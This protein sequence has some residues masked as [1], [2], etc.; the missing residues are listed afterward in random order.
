MY[1]LRER[2]QHVTQE[3]FEFAVAKVRSSFF[4]S[5]VKHPIGSQF[6]HI[7]PEKEPRREHKCQQTL[8]LDIMTCI[9]GYLYYRLLCSFRPFAIEEEQVRMPQKN[10][11]LSCSQLKRALPRSIDSGSLG[12]R[13]FTSDQVRTA[14]G[15]G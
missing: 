13:R 7:G 12:K 11:Y 1:A 3:D 9:P 4:H 5:S 15:F 10:L 6:V 8:Q 2:R 14:F